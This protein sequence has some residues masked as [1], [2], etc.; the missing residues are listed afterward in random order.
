MLKSLYAKLLAVLV[1]LTLIT[2]MIFLVVIRYS[3]TARN[4]ELNQKLYRNLASRL[5]NEHILAEQDR[6]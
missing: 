4:Q 6:A 3:D 1:G 5:I 2:A